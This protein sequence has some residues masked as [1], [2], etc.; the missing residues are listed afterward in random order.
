M[1][2]LPTKENGLSKITKM[3]CLG[4][5]IGNPTNTANLYPIDKMDCAVRMYQP[6]MNNFGKFVFL[7]S[8][9]AEEELER[10]KYERFEAVK[11]I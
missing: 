7:S 9:E 11:K 3:K 10:I 6:D 4:F 1:Y 8:E 5:S 2:V